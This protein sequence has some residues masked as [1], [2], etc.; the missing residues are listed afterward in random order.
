MKESTDLIPHLFKTEHS[1]LVAVL[2]KTFG[3]DHVETAEDIASETF[4][5]AMAVWPYKGVPQNP[6]AWL[7]AVAK[8]KAKNQLTRHRVFKEKI[9]PAIKLAQEQTCVD[10]IDLSDQN[11]RDSQLQMLFAICHPSIPQDAQIC[12][13]L[14]LLCGFGLEEIANAFFTNKETIHKRLQRAKNKLRTE[15]VTIAMPH[16]H[17]LN[18]RL[19]AV[20]R[21]IYLLFSEGYYSESNA[22]IVRKELCVEA[23]NLTHL[24]L[25]NSATSIH[26]VKALMS[27]MCFH[28]SRLEARQTTNGDLILYDDQDETK[29][30]TE[31]IEKGFY[32]LQQASKWETVSK[33]YI[34][35]SIAYWHTVKKEVA[36]KWPSILKLYDVL[37]TIDPSPIIRLNRLFAV[38]KVHGNQAA[39]R[40]SVTLNL[41]DNHFYWMLLAELHKE[42]D[43]KKAITCLQQALTLCKTEPEKRGIKEKIDNWTGH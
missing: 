25:S 14:R 38:S 3:L 1:K 40:E 20:L 33:Y 28:A 11:I 5:E 43:I 32:Y 37:L 29:W 19:D 42:T 22:A 13:A 36:D 18:S 7:Y 8:N 12:L 30:N 35:A 31:L 34:E 6:V 17:E 26:A 27:L 21:T 9:L 10:E 2:V 23:I 39:I 24:L 41:N 16:A 15:N 4:L